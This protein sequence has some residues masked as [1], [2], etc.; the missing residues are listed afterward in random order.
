MLKSLL[1]AL[2][3]LNGFLRFLK[4]A[5]GY[6]KIC[7]VIYFD[8]FSI[9]DTCVYFENVLYRVS[10]VGSKIHECSSSLFKMA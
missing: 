4:R 6:L 8:F 9:C 1:K 5:S 10:P 7:S 3:I 2:A